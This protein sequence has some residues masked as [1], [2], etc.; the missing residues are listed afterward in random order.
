MSEPSW[1]DGDHVAQCMGCSE[2]D[3]DIEDDDDD[4][5]LDPDLFHD[6]F[7]D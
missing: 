6:G 1:L 7:Y 2:C 4:D 5:G 3:D